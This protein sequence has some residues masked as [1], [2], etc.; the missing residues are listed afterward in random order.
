MW[1]FVWGRSEA[2]WGEQRPD[3]EI[4]CDGAGYFGYGERM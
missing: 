2:K 4:V 1:S 3:A